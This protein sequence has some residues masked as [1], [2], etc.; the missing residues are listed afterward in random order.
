MNLSGEAS[1]G[2]RV[3]TA[4]H[5]SAD[6]SLPETNNEINSTLLCHSYD[7]DPDFETYFAALQTYAWVIFACGLAVLLIICALYVITLRS[8][9]KH[10]RDQM[11]HVAV[12]LSIYPIVAASALVMIVVP[13]SRLPAEAVAQEAVMVALY[14]FFCLVIAECGGTEQF[15]RSAGGAD[16]ETRVMPCCCWPCCVIPRPKLHKGSLMWLRYLVLQIPIIQGLIYFILIVIWSEDFML[17]Q[18]NFVYFQPFIAASIL[19]G[20]WGV[21]MCVRAAISVG[22]APRPRFLVIQLV[23]IIVKL[24]CGLAKSVPNMANLSCVMKLHP[25]VFA[26]LINN[27]IMMLEMLLI[28]IWAWRVY[29]SPPG[30]DMEKVQRDRVVVAVL[31]DNMR[32]IEVKSIKDGIDNKSFNNNVPEI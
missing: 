26:S 6:I 28:S 3:L 10:W 30:K 15:V 8:A 29:S 25:G 9:V 1:S 24:Q 31:E 27:C 17:Y 5:I 2:P 4:R 23:L 11:H 18:G 19:S 32:S 14:H 16:L 22:R 7:L 21:V 13:R 12:V 20:M